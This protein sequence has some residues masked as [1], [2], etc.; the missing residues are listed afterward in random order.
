MDFTIGELRVIV[1]KDYRLY[2]D[3]PVD[4]EQPHMPTISAED[5]KVLQSKLS[6]ILQNKMLDD[7]DNETDQQKKVRKN[8]LL[9]WL[10]SLKEIQ[11]G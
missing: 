6:E 3:S 7:L 9:S 4:D 11:N 5:I 8:K 10:E 2:F 1:G